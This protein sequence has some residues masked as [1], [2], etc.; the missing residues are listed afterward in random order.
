MEQT[1]CGA[2]TR[3]WRACGYVRLSREDGS[4]EESSS[5][6]GQKAL[7]HDYFRLHD[8]LSD[9][10]IIADDGYSGSCFDRP[11]FLELM[12]EVRAGTIDCIVVKDLSRFG[13]NYLDAGEYIEK[14]FPFLGVRFIAI[15]DNYDSENSNP[16]F[17]RLIIPFK[18][19]I[20][21]LYCRDSSMKIRSQLAA[22]RRR[23]EFTGAFAVYGYQKDPVQKNHLIADRFAADVVRDIFHWKLEGISSADIA[24]RLNADGILPPMDY[25][26]SQGIRF[27]TPFRKHAYSSWSAAAI[28][29]I[30]KNP[31]YTGVLEQGKHTTPSYKVKKRIC[32]PREEWSVTAGVHEAII[33]PLVFASVQKALAMDTRT[34]PGARAV[35][36]FSGMVYCGECGAAMIRKTVPA[37]GKKYVYYICAAHKNYKTCSAHSMRDTVLQELVFSGLQTQI[38]AVI[39]VRQL[40]QLAETAL[41]YHTENQKLQ[42]RLQKKNEEAERYLRLLHSLYESLQ[43]HMI[44]TDEYQ[45]MKK[46][47]STCY[48]Q[49]MEQTEKLEQQLELEQ[50]NAVNGNGWLQQ[51]TA[52]GRFPALDRIGVVTLIDRIFLFA[53]NRIEIIYNWKDAL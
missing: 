27:A 32:V 50:K 36:L 13:R 51:R 7:I 10:G 1:H 5:I 15:Q 53:G 46:R 37:G 44:D 11:G 41:T 38:C 22:K 26:K 12:A 52:S 45:K 31:V 16:S 47:Y 33:D 43:D 40:Q 14:I 30:L 3:I 19:L 34:S 18:N 20:N 9:C 2:N 21:E 6:A 42:E 8:D 49:A 28:L 39:G 29:R 4:Q 48:T 24:D 35:E 23:G 25:K 17:D